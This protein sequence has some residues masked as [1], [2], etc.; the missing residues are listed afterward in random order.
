MIRTD[1]VVDFILSLVVRELYESMFSRT[2]KFLLK[3]K[4]NPLSFLPVEYRPT[5]LQQE[6]QF[7]SFR[8][9]FYFISQAACICPSLC[10]VP[11]CL[12][13]SSS[14]S[15]EYTLFFL[16]W[17]SCPQSFWHQ[18]LFSWK[19]NFPWTRWDGGWFGDDSRA[20]HLLCTLFLIT[21]ASLQCF[22]EC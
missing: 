2:F 12:C 6:N 8:L 11:W 10:H 13:Y 14:N 15:V 1:Q 3:K 20:L 5:F 7:S 18:V 16:P 22:P 21:S 4:K 17:S 19:T 9:I